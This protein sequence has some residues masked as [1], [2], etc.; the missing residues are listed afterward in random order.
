MKRVLIIGLDGAS[1]HLVRRWQDYLPNLSRLI[2]RGASGTLWSV[3]PP[4]SIPAWYC[5]A[6]GMNPAKIGVFGFS[7]R[8]PGTY[9]YTFAN[10]TFCRAPAF[11]QWLNRYGIRTAVIHMPGTFPPHPVKGVMVSGW[12]APIN[13][14]NLIYTHPPELSRELDN[15]IGHPFEFASQKPMRLDNDA[16]M[17][18]ERLRILRMHGKVARYVLTRY[19]CDVG[20]VVFGQID[21][22]SHQFWRHMD[23]HHPAYDPTLANQFRDALR[24][25]YQAADEE[26]GRLLELLDPEDT[27]FIVSDHGF[28]PAYRIFYLNEWLRRNGYLILKKEE[29]AGKVGLRTRIIGKL[30]APL[31]WLNNTSP[32]FRRLIAPL[33]K[34][35][36]S[37]F[38]RDEYVR[39]KERGL[40][41]IHHLPVDWART[42]AYCPD[43][44]SL[45][46]N[47][48]GRDPQGTVEAGPQAKTLLE[49]I[50]AGL[51][52]I[53]D[54]QTGKPVKITLYRKEDIYKGPFLA[55]APEIIVVMDDYT[56]E[57][58][59]ELGSGELFV[60]S[61]TR[62]GTHTP[63]GLFIAYGPEIPE[64]VNVS[65]GIMDI[66]PTTLHLMD[67]PIPE[68]TDGRVLLEL[69]KEGSPP[70]QRPIRF[71]PSPIARHTVEEYTEEE[72]AQVEKQ[73]RDLGY[74]G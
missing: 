72:Q 41:R 13:R 50:A 36:L 61:R 12:P 7:Q 62:S 14:G 37:N 64:G 22:A 17:L 60:P 54:P 20:I 44:A 45:Y 21:R 34:R 65:P 26:V 29:M 27:V 48:R 39:A 33:K 74:L 68:E 30:S 46:L 56:T 52:T 8:R 5:F 19:D 31:I 47:L 1:P 43:E 11:W 59:A 70:A 73:L 63:E 2:K 16:E 38:I 4:R 10:L 25:V 53:P 23:P 18:E 71:E 49:E 67:V 57:V 58:M 55:E 40:V 69:F 66:A 35:A 28:G 6:T 3:I 9:D 42:K 32:T 51:R 15:Y 24:Q